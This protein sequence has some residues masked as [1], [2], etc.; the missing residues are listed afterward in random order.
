MVVTRTFFAI[1]ALM[2]FIVDLRCKNYLFEI[3]RLMKSC[4]VTSETCLQ[5]PYETSIHLEITPLLTSEKGKQRENS[6]AVC[7]YRL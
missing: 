4:V 2:S 7:L 1:L 6:T 5:I 3:W